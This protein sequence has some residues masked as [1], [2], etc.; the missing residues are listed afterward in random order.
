MR[1]EANPFLKY[2]LYAWGL[3]ALM[4]IAKV[5]GDGIFTAELENYSSC[6]LNLDYENNCMQSYFLFIFTKN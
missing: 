1:N 6:L 5:L 2:S 3:P 4:T